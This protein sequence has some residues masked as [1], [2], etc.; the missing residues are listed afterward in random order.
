[1]SSPENPIVE[2]NPTALKSIDEF[3]NERTD[4]LVK[5]FHTTIKEQLKDPN[6]QFILLTNSDISFKKW[7]AV[8]SN[9]PNQTDH[10]F[11]ELT[12]KEDQKNPVLPPE[13]LK[14]VPKLVPIYSAS[15][16]DYYT[17]PENSRQYFAENIFSY[18]N[19]SAWKSILEGDKT[20][21]IQ[22]N[23]TERIKYIV[24]DFL[25]SKDK[26]Y[27]FQIGWNS[28]TRD[29]QT[30]SFIDYYIPD[31]SNP[32]K[33]LVI[34][35]ELKDDLQFIEFSDPLIT[36]ELVLNFISPEAG[37]NYLFPIENDL[38]PEALQT[39]LQMKIE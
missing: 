8:W 26:Q 28:G 15:A 20:L 31:S 3:E 37:I 9:N 39:F 24:I 11:E 23:K 22:F 19:N 21:K 1:M 14:D 38:S 6:K 32:E 16:N 12:E 13:E 10:L 29:K 34:T 5:S 7:R 25:D 33:R 36:T 18:D 17:D 27:Q 30:G 4:R 2:N 35:T